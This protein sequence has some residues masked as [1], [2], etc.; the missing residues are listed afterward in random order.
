MA[1][2]SYVE[3][4][5]A[6]VLD[7]IGQRD[8]WK[9]PI[10]INL[11]KV[12][13]A[14]PFHPLCQT[15]FIETEAG[16]KVEIDI[17]LETEKFEEVRFPQQIIGGVLIEIANRNHLPASGQP[18]AKPPAW[19][20][21]ALAQRLQEH[22]TDSR[23]NAALFKQLIDTGKLPHIAEFLASNVD[24]M[25]STSRTLYGACCESLLQMLIDLPGGRQ[26][27]G[28]LVN[29]LSQS[30]D[31]PGAQLL[32]YFSALGG[33]DAALE[34]WWTLGLA[35]YA[36]ADQYLGMTVK[37]TE[38]HIVPL[39]NLEIITDPKK[40]TKTTFA[41][42]D[43]R[44]FLKIRSAA[45]V[46]FAHANAF[47]ALG[48]QANPLMRPVTLEYQRLLAEMAEG[49]AHKVDARLR[50]LANYRAMVV[51]R[52]DKIADYLNWF[53]ATQMPELS[54]AFNNYMKAASELENEA[55]PKR[56]DAISRYVDQVEQEFEN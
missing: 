18:Y 15:Q 31:P 41:I 23:P 22:E 16:A 27:L 35:R 10:I 34:K 29:N 20:V 19:L 55:P 8:H 4:A 37:E 14:D 52:M 56:N 46:L 44:K 45:N 11:E 50:D 12:A 38:D 39:L 49:K 30:Q 13:T 42:T 17:A 5:K 24:V 21:E 53:E 28:K 54:G 48:A 3:T 43:Y 33:S 7:A 36:A 32:K 6:A 26:S 25:D 40:G 1:V 9:Y 2:T 51:E 47:S